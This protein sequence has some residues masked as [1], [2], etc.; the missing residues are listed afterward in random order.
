MFACFCVSVAARSLEKMEF[1]EFCHLRSGKRNDKQKQ[2][3]AKT[4]NETWK[5]APNTVFL[6]SAEIETIRRK[7]FLVRIRNV[8]PGIQYCIR[9]NN[10]NR[11]NL[12]NVNRTTLRWKQKVFDL[13]EREKNRNKSG[14]DGER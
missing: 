12:A 14:D 4:M 3:S 1:Q 6:I 9:N 2:M 8:I 10:N 11:S 13:M 5:V 7:T